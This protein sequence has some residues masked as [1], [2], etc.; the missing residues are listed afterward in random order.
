[1]RYISGKNIS[2]ENTII[3]YFL[4]EGYNIV[5]DTKKDLYIVYNM[6]ELKNTIEQLK[7]WLTNNNKIKK[8]EQITNFLIYNSNLEVLLRYLPYDK[9]NKFLK[10]DKM[11]LF[12]NDLTL[13]DI[14]YNYYKDTKVCLR[15]EDVSIYNGENRFSSRILDNIKVLEISK[16]TSI[17]DNL[18]YFNIIDEDFNFHKYY[19]PTNHIFTKILNSIIDFLKGIVYNRFKN[20]RKGLRLHYE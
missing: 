5:F 18:D 13:E 20:N 15:L 7:H 16:K 19:F 10:E 12:E 8:L 17:T 9:N 14:N 6:E 3:D 1:M 2:S 11:I 4:S